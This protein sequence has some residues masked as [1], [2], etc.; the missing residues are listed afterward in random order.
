MGIYAT[1]NIWHGQEV[2]LVNQEQ[3]SDPEKDS[4][5]GLVEESELSHEWD[6]DGNPQGLGEGTEGSRDSPMESGWKT[7]SPRNPW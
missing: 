5:L 4:R 6:E 3:T 7:Y 2:M 1:E